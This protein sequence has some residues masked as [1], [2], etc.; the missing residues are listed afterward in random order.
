MSNVKRKLGLFMSV[1]LIVLLIVGCSKSEKEDDLTG[2][3]ETNTPVSTTDDKPST[4]EAI[5]FK[6]NT[7][8]PQARWDTPISKKLTETTGVSFE[9]IPI[10]GGSDVAQQK[11]D[12][13]LASG[14]YP[15]VLSLQPRVLGKYRDAGALMPLE[16]LIEQYGPNIKKKFGKFYNLLKDADGHIYS[17]YNVQTATET[18]AN[19]QAN[20]AIQYEV[21]KEAGYPEIKTLDQLY[22]V[23]FEYY[24]KHPTIDGQPTIP[25]SGIG[26]NFVYNNPTL[27]AGGQPDHGNFIIDSENQVHL[28]LVSDNSKKYYQF[29]NKLY[30]EGLLDKEIF[31]L[32]YDTAPSKIAQGRILAGYYPEWFL[33]APE[34]SIKSSGNLNRQYAKLPILFDANVEDHSNAFTPTWSNNNW[35]ISKNNKHPE[36]VIQFIDYLFTDEGQKLISWGIEG[37]DYE[38]K[39]GKRFRSD[40]IIQKMAA[41][42]DYNWK[43]G[44]GNNYNRFSFG[45][46]AKLDDGDYATPLTKE[47]MIRGYDDVTKEVLAAYKK[48][49]WADFLPPLE[50]VPSFLWQIAEPEGAAALSKRIQQVWDRESPKLVM[51]K[52]FDKDW[53]K[54]KKLIESSGQKELEEMYNKAWKVVVDEYNKAMGQ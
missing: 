25:F 44:L 28:N 1:L 4:P 2:T 22:D 23:L 5:T 47:Y 14:D 3:T 40:E 37:V 8:D 16:D 6:I 46:G 9:Y 31:T 42:S 12:L 43:Q 41:D 51:S 27:S 13:W 30:A 17:L 26:S 29:L 54:Y 20:F 18:P 39:D 45:H 34:S 21:L 52:N 24:K 48:D 33:S 32:T 38:I 19:S 36:R 35:A 15:E 11:Y 50:Y 10:I 53:E 7:T 49:T